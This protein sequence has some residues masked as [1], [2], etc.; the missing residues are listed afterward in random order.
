MAKTLVELK[1]PLELPSNPCGRPGT[2]KPAEL[3]RGGGH[4]KIAEMIEAAIRNRKR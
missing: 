2:G 4:N 1:A 3:A